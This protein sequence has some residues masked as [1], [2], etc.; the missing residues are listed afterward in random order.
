MIEYEYRLENVVNVFK[1]YDRGY[2]D[3][4]IVNNNNKLNFKCVL[5]LTKICVNVSNVCMQNLHIANRFLTK[6][7]SLKKVF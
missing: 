7:I 1:I 3:I 2:I 6:I 5:V 4:N